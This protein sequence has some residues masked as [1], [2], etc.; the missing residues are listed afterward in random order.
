MR[1]VYTDA[2]YFRSENKSPEGKRVELAPAYIV[3]GGVAY[4]IRGFGMQLQYAHTA[5]QFTDANNT[6]TSANGIT[7]VIPAYGVA[8]LSASYEYRRLKVSAGCSN[9][10]N[11]KYFTRRANGYPGP[12]ILPSDP[13]NF[14]LTPGVTL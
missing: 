13:R 9:L 10:L 1:V 5:Q 12:G 3:R 2:R 4:R 11:A 6:L 14:Y 8:D 7:G